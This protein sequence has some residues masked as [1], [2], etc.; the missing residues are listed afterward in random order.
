MDIN[1]LIRKH[2]NIISIRERGI[3]SRD[4]A[5]IVLLKI[6]NDIRK[7]QDLPA[8]TELPDNYRRLK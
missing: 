7:E 3:I 4:E 6:V 2:N 5:I 1:E 8:L